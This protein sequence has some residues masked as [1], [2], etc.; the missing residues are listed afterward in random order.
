MVK[1]GIVFINGTKE[2]N[3]LYEK[4]EEEEKLV[5]LAQESDDIVCEISS[6]FP[7][8]LFPDQVVV[9]KNKVIVI[10]NEF[11]YKR[12][13][14]ILTEDI[15]TVRVTRG[16]IFASLEFEV[17]GYK[18]NPRPVTHLRPD[19]ALKAEEYILG[20]VKAGR[21]KV[22]LSTLPSRE[23]RKELEVVGKTSYK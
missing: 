7:F 19:D 11:M 18:K 13:F 4:T 14:P 17:V 8:Q 23:I 3:G 12:T 6:V 16:A 2:Q 9:D 21:K 1:K 10:R 5:N 20:L 22:D 15:Q